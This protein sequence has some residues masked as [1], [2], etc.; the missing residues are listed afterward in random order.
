M[1]ATEIVEQSGPDAVATETITWPRKV[2]LF[3]VGVTPTTYDEATAVIVSA[4]QAG[5]GGVVS[6]QAVHAVMT[7]CSDPELCAQVNTFDMVTPDGQPVRWALNVLHGAGLAERVYGPELMLQLCRKASET[8]VSVYL[9]GGSPEVVEALR[10][11]LQQQFPDLEIAGYESP[12]FRPLTAEEDEAVVEQ[13]NSSGAGLVFIGLGCPK[14]DIFAYEHRG[15]IKGVQLCVGAA[16][17]FHAGA[18]SSA[19]PWMQRRGLEWLYRL[20]Q[21]PRRLWRRYFETNTLYLFKFAASLCNV[22]R[23]LR[24]RRASRIARSGR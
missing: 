24:Q 14:Q 5:Q 6:C 9:Y 4:A 19:P 12:P 8:G 18:K 23:V 17:D 11:N 21:E 3:G 10:F 22:S 13:I 15:R 16:F 2:D 1:Q 20:I 7:A